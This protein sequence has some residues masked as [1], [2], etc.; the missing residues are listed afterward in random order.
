MKQSFQKTGW[1][2]ILYGLFCIAGYTL[3]LLEGK[4]HSFLWLN[5]YHR[6]WLDR[7][8]MLYTYVGDGL[9]A[10]LL[11]LILFFVLRQ[12]K[13]GL[14]LLFAYALT[15]IVAQVIKPLVEAP[16]PGSYFREHLPFFIDAIQ[17]HGRT[18]FPSGHTVTAFALT[19][20][21]A[22]YTRSRWQHLVL[23]LLAVLAGYSRIYL[24]QHF[25]EDVMAGSLIG[26][27]G[28]GLS[29]YWFRRVGDEHLVLKRRRR[30]AAGNGSPHS[31]S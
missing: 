16:R 29:E 9:F 26:V 31:T 20:V 24:S 7:L 4:E 13:M 19:T 23:I 25:L 8:F 11:S 17:H 22:F 2:W 5:S 15:G 30:S 18:S 27:T 28:A 21:L 1:Y 3:L 10:V 14:V 12:R 6:P